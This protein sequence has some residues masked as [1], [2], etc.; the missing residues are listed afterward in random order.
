[1]EIS[2]YKNIF[3]VE[4][5]HFFY[6]G[7]RALILSLLKA[8]S[9]FK[10]QG[11]FKNQF[12]ILDAGCGTGLLLKK[13]QNY[14]QVIGV[15]ISSEAIKYT[16]KRGLKKVY[17]ASVEKIP[18]KG[19][20]F[21]VVISIDVLYH[22]QVKNDVEALKEFYRILKPTGILI[23]KLPAFGWLRG[24][25]DELVQAK[26]RYTTQELAT[27]LTKAGFHINKITYSNMFF[28]PVVFLKRR[29]ENL[30]S[31]DIESDIGQ[32]PP[33]LNKV[34]ILIQEIEVK[35]LNYINLPFGVSVIAVAQKD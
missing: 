21:D 3:D 1:M 29:L 18:F 10:N 16:K 23:I 26:R 15:D 28:L 33:L 5:S 32:V 13:L 25:H 4:E 31:P 19:N 34:L 12:K 8:Y 2:E 22:K 27:K 14:G 11:I 24:K 30:S 20:N 9:P 6:V 35:L 17:K 7:T